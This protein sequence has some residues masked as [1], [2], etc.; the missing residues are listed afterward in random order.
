MN[1]QTQTQTPTHEQDSTK[2]EMSTQTHNQDPSNNEI[3]FRLEHAMLIIQML[4]TISDDPSDSYSQK[5]I[6]IFG[7]FVL[8]TMI[9]KMDTFEDIDVAIVRGSECHES[10]L[11]CFGIFDRKNPFFTIINLLKSIGYTLE[12]DRID[13][14]GFYQFA[15]GKRIKRFE[16]SVLGFK[17][18]KFYYP[19]HLDFT[20]QGIFN[21]FMDD[22][23]GM[24]VIS[25]I[26]YISENDMTPQTRGNI[27][28]TIPSSVTMLEVYR[29]ICSKELMPVFNQYVH[30][31]LPQ[32]RTVLDSMIYRYLKMMSK[33]YHFNGAT[34]FINK[35]RTATLHQIRQEDT[36]LM[37]SLEDESCPICAVH[38]TGHDAD[39]HPELCKETIVRTGK[40]VCM[41]VLLKTRCCA[42]AFHIKCIMENVIFHM[43]HP[44]T[45]DDTVKSEP[46]NC[47][48]C[49][50]E[51]P[52][53][54]IFYRD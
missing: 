45:A 2:V 22:L 42:K 27:L 10:A 3:K 33:G 12:S 9:Q 30:E 23:S 34:S 43:S 5:I 44:N 35:T 51:S 41:K 13:V 36:E 54:P 8:D 49:R 14:K 31:D 37:K 32:F 4:F 52:L 19:I 53:F 6:L 7:G 11:N 48:N 40:D 18:E 39:E 25:N 47:P 50:D 46:L 26:F 28:E 17:D 15:N 29:R 21:D 16:I 20:I 24:D 38:F 1:V